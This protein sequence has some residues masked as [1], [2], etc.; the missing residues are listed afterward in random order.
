MNIL[1]IGSGAREHAI[2]RT[3]DRS[4]KDKKI[5]CLGSNVNPGIAELCA[6]FTVA[7][8]NHKK[9]I[10]NYADKKAVDLAIIGPE[11]PLAIGAT[12]ALWDIGVKV[13]GPMKDLAQIETSKVF[14][15]DLLTEYNIPGSLKY[16]KFS[17][18]VGVIEFL[19]E[20]GENYV[21]KFDGLAGGKG[22]KVSGDHLHSH[23]D[24]K[25]YCQELVEKGG[26]FILEEK[27]IGQ[28][29]SLMS[30]CDGKTLKHMPADRKSTRLN[31]SHW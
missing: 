20:L 29:F 26:V 2:V 13:V 22:V 24:A 9:T 28:E 19:N 14:A 4:E 7:N 21:V 31:S 12:D 27:L 17:S 10:T 16:K 15:R 5:F 18:L 30:F 6:D 1:V 25:V 3:I 8:I 11:N 23:E